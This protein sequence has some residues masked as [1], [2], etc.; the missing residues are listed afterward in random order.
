M[1]K[2]YIKPEFLIESLFSETD[3]AAG[4]SENLPYP[5]YDEDKDQGYGPWVPLG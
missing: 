4:E 2:E 3:I 5:G 1:N